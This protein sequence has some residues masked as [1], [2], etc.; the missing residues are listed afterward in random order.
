MSWG[1]EFLQNRFCLALSCLLPLGWGGKVGGA[2][3]ACTF[4]AMPDKSTRNSMSC[5]KQ[6]KFLQPDLRQQE[7][8]KKKKAD[9]QLRATCNL[10]THT[11]SLGQQ[12][13][14]YI[15]NIYIYVKYMFVREL[16]SGVQVELAASA[17]CDF[18]AQQTNC[19]R[20]CFKLCTLRSKLKLSR[21]WSHSQSR[22]R[23]Q[24]R[25]RSRRSA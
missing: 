9:W 16:K 23:S 7:K 4:M 15:R 19:A 1:R 22:D 20:K 17:V 2:G 8:R 11:H 21:S 3:T 10:H 14:R 25:A 5:K 24:A 6:L 12:K 18:G 13:E